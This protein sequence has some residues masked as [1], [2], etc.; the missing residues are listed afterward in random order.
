MSPIPRLLLGF[1]F[2]DKLI[3]ITLTQLENRPVGKANPLSVFLSCN[4]NYG[5]PQLN[6]FVLQI[7]WKMVHTIKK[8]FL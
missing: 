1:L 3:G 4:K 8:D 7:V 5:I 2:P 6:L